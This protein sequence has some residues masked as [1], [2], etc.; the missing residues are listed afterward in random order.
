MTPA[1]S[2]VMT[3]I[4]DPDRV[5]ALRKTFLLDTK[6][7]EA[8]DR[9]TN[10]AARVLGAP[11]SFISL[12]DVNRHYVKSGIGASIQELPLSHSFCKHVVAT[13]EPLIVDD[14]RNHPAVR[15]NPAIK[16]YDVIG[17]LGMP[18]Y[19]TDGL[20]I[21]SLCVIDNKPRQWSEDEISIIRDLTS[22]VMMEIEL[23]VQIRMEQ[24]AGRKLSTEEVYGHLPDDGQRFGVYEVIDQ[25]GT[26]GMS[27][28][29]LSRHRFLKNV[30]AVKQLRAN[31]QNYEEYT[32]RFEQEAQIIAQLKHQNIVRVFDYGIKD[33]R[34]YMIM[35]HIN[36]VDLAEFLGRNER[37]TFGYDGAILLDIAAALDYAHS[38]GIIHRDV[39]PSNVMLRR[40]FSDGKPMDQFHAIL[41][42]F[43][44]ARLASKGTNMTQDNLVGTVSYM[45]PEQIESSNSLDY[46]ADLYS[47]GVLTYQFLTGHLPFKS[48]S[49]A[50]LLRM[51]LTDPMPD[52]RQYVPDLTDNQVDALSLM[53]S[54]DPDDRPASAREFV[55]ML[56]K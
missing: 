16:E 39:K 26:G 12:I 9:L 49:F 38:K 1:T 40:R 3:Q 18:I 56:G 20:N 6:A 53:L 42:D 14:A 33:E 47:F 32:K 8:F 28:V 36:G 21:G 13:G 44:I 45:A 51:H 35:E 48:G 7:E 22:S 41:M 24:E 29:Y 2:N 52:P 10:M 17:Y 19:T 23:R 55:T 15:H 4:V 5:A 34:P 50:G 11:I 27:D 31:V 46:R 25:I 54:K 43:G 37:L 30:V